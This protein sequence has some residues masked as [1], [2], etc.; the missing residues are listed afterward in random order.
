MPMSTAFYDRPAAAAAFRRY[1]KTWS[2]PAAWTLVLLHCARDT[3]V[4]FAAALA[5]VVY[6]IPANG[7]PRN[8]RQ[9]RLREKQA[10]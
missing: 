6:G 3:N 1:R 4:R 10:A 7:I 5:L 9:E 8:E 2:R